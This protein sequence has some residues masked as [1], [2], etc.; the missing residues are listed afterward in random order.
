M[1]LRGNFLRFLDANIF[2]YAFY[3]PRK[4][5]SEKAKWMKEE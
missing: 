5:P 3:K 1:N 2:I 4:E